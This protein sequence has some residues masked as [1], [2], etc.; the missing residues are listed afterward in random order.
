MHKPVPF[1]NL[2]L[3]FPHKICFSDFS[4]QIYCGDRIAIIGRNGCGK[5]LLLKILQG[6][7]EP[8]SGEIHHPADLVFSYVP[9]SMEGAQGLS[10]GEHL[11]DVLMQAFMGEP[12]F[13]LLDEPTNHLDSRHR[14]G[15]FRQ[16]KAF[17]GTLVV[18]T[19]DV[20]VLNKYVD[21]IWHI[22]NEVIHVFS[23]DYLENKPVLEEICF[24]ITGD[25]RVALQGDNGSGKS[26]L[27]K[28]ILNDPHVMKQGQWHM[29]AVSEIGYLDQHYATLP[30]DKKV[31]EVI[32]AALPHASYVELRKYLNDFLFRKNEEIEADLSSLSGGE[33]ARLSLA[34]IAAQSPKLLILDEMTNNLDLETREHVITV[35]KA[36]SGAMIV[37][38]HDKDFLE[39]IN[40]TTRYVI[41]QGL[42]TPVGEYHE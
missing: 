41:H 38:S 34:Q 29:P 16:L 10:G 13:L 5:S 26:S 14:Q 3:S 35:L 19:H 20:E 18:V 15:L 40:I 32:M 7:L 27:I 24:N 33:K 11:Y 6:A 42:I 28:A 9:Q 12:N 22:D 21:K 30:A 8:S 36:Y 31:I 23:G 39:K 17:S 1:K 4:G 2:S 37:I 25:E